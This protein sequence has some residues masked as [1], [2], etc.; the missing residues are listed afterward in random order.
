M[1]SKAWGLPAQEEALGK[2]TMKV[3]PVPASESRLIFA[4]LTDCPKLSTEVWRLRCSVLRE[5]P[6]LGPANLN[7]KKLNGY[8]DSRFHGNDRKGWLLYSY[9]AG[10]P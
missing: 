7:F 2:E 1:T 10:Y 6:M 8:L 9:G 4:R 5:T 3:A